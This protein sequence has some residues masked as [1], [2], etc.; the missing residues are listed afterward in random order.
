VV[1]NLISVAMPDGSSIHVARHQ[2]IPQ[3]SI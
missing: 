1:T 3:F 2:H